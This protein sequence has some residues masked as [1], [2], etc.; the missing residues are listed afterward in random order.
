[1]NDL[2]ERFAER[3][4]GLT[5]A[6]GIYR[7]KGKATK[8]E[9]FLG[10]AQTVREEPTVEKWSLHLSGKQGL[11]IVPIRDDS[12]VRFGALDIDVYDDIDHFALYA[13][14]EALELPL[15]VCRSK[16]GGAHIYLFCRED[17]PAELVRDK[18]MEWSVELGHSGTEVFPKQT[19]LAGLSDIGNWIN[20]PYFYAEKTERYCVLGKQQL[21]AKAFLEYAD[22]IAVTAAQL[23]TTQVVHHEQVSLF[24]NGPPCLKTLERR[25]GIPKG[26]RNNGLFNIG[27][28]LRKR[29]KDDWEDH[30]DEYN[31][32]M[33]QPP[34]GHKEVA[35]IARSVNRKAYEF[36]CNDQPI[37]D[38]CNKQVCLKQEFGVSG[39]DNDPGVVFGSLI[40]LNTDPVTWIWDVNGARIEL[41]TVEL[42]D[43]A[44]FH[45]RAI[46]ELNKWPQ[47]IKPA[48]WAKLVR[49]KLEGCETIDVPEDARPSGQVWTFLEQ[50]C[51]SQSRARSREELLMRKPYVE[52]GRTYFHA[53]HFQQFLAKQGLRVAPRM[54]WL[55]LK[56]R[57]AET[58][59]MNI[60][61]RGINVWSIPSFAEQDED[62]SVPTIEE[63][64]REV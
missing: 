33:V 5:R 32:S 37:C 41:T 19:R 46:E 60:K 45:T 8:G 43:Q 17:V 34:L 55:W 10:E 23:E 25:G 58:E 16:S 54:L 2:A 61:G 57:G 1:M 47:P 7:L 64:A 39:G 3:F 35:D 51:M 38:H 21:S 28:Y 9:K 14:V 62:F 22:Q 30:L 15:A 31:Q 53:P 24:F 36:K 59:F 13:K 20:M 63:E 27:V 44:R 42:K 6:H 11:G 26:Q 48:E 49:D 50:Y 12:T 29:Y 40:K 4:A 18:L 52:N 56:A